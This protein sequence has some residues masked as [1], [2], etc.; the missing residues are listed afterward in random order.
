MKL[1]HFKMQYFFKD[2]SKYPFYA[3]IGA[4]HFC[5]GSFWNYAYF[6][7]IRIPETTKI[8]EI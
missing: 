2:F 8:T 5:I 4:H 7:D 1:K 3:E 6:G